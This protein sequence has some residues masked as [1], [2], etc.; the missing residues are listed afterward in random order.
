MTWD[1]TIP[2]A[3][4]HSNL[5]RTSAVSGATAEEASLRMISKYTGV[6]QRY[7]LNAIAIESLGPINENGLI[8]LREIGKRLTTI[9]GDHAKPAFSFSAFL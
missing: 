8:F 9:S 6:K 4:A 2:D 5:P 1:V 7:D 3:L